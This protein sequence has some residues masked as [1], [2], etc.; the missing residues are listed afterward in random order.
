MM[1]KIIKISCI[2]LGVILL[3]AVALIAFLSITEYLP[4]DKEPAARIQ[5]DPSLSKISIG[6]TVTVYTWN[7]GYGGLGKD[8]DFFMD[9]GEMV[10]PPNQQTVEQNLAAIRSFMQQRNADAWLL[11]EVDVDSART[12]GMDQFDSIHQAVGGSAAFAYNYNCPFVPIPLPPIGRVESGIAT[13]SQRLMT[14]DAERVS[15]PCPFSWPIRAAQSKRC[16]LIT[17][18]PLEGSDKQLVLVNLH[19]EAY[20]DGDGKRAQTELLMQ[21]LQQEY[22]KGNYVIAG[23]DFN[24]TFPGTLD[25][26]PV[27]DPE[28]WTPGILEQEM[29][30]QGWHFAYDTS[31][32]TCR[33]LD[34]PLTQDTQTFV[35]DG[36]ILSPNVTAVTVQTEDLGFEHSDHNPIR[37][38]LKL[39]P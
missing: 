36:F 39:D 22:Q 33:L 35:I 1:K 5:T 11:Q 17:R 26:Y 21:V 28:K 34:A 25:L 37:L 24:Q 3:L 23:G 10:D 8:S 18:L 38:E 7:I 2:V 9:G 32:P 31:A 20:D 4:E 27:S 12:D 6:D 30:P 29:L 15:L 13:Y 16:L 14:A 19:L